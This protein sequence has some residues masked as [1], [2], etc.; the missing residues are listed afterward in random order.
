MSHENGQRCSNRLQG[1]SEELQ[2]NSPASQALTKYFY[3]R[4]TLSGKC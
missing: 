1:V 4:I 3:I 2:K